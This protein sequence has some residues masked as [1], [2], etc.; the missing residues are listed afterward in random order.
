MDMMAKQLPGLASP[1]PVKQ[2]FVHKQIPPL[3]TT[4]SEKRPIGSSKL[5]TGS[6][7]VGRPE[8]MLASLPRP[9]PTTSESARYSASV[10]GS[11]QEFELC[12]CLPGSCECHTPVEGGMGVGLAG[13]GS[14]VN[15]RVGFPCPSSMKCTPGKATDDA[16]PT[17]QFATCK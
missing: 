2:A 14:C 13:G 17:D 12:D 4:G 10:D 5:D 6:S 8:P 3:P 11:D 9:P 1:G 15:C 16:P 7:N